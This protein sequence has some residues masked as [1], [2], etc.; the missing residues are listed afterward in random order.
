MC[1]DKGAPKSQIFY[2]T[3][4]ELFR[5]LLTGIL[6]AKDV[7]PLLLFFNVISPPIALAMALLHAKPIPME[8]FSTWLRFC[9]SLSSRKGTKSIF[10]R[11]FEIPRPLSTISVSKTNWSLET[12]SKTYEGLSG[13]HLRTKAISPLKTL[14]LIAF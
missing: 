2:S 5:I 12:T 7:R 13:R 10:Q 9:F 3:A 11:S 4:S 8:L 1:F 6:K 14:N